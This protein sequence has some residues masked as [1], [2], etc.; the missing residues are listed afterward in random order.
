MQL[1]VKVWSWGERIVALLGGRT[2]TMLF[3]ALITAI[4]TVIFTDN[5]IVTFSRQV[6]VLRVLRDNIV[7]LHELKI[8][9]LQAE[10]A[11]RGYLLTSRDAYVA[12]FNLAIKQA[13]NHLKTSEALLDE[14]Q[15]AENKS[16]NLD[17]LKAI[18]ASVEAKLKGATYASREVNK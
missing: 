6:E 18:S 13:R 9:L 8:D 12:P 17:L 11:Q 4:S 3:I 15:I 2:I 5:W 16:F 10:S 7:V 14:S 1:I